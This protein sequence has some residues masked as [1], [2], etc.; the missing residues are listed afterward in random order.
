MWQQQPNRIRYAIVPS[1]LL[2]LFSPRR[3]CS[4]LVVVAIICFLVIMKFM[5]TIMVVIVFVT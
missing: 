1:I 4:V 3:A 2:L 5:I